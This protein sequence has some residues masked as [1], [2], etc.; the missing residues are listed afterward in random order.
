MKKI[1]LVLLLGNFALSSCKK[2]K[3]APENE[4]VDQTPS[5]TI[6]ASSSPQFTG[7]LDGTT[8]NYN[9]GYH[10]S[11]NSGGSIGTNP[12]PSNFTFGF[13]I[14]NS[15]NISVLKIEKG[16][17]I[18]PTGGY[19]TNELFGSFFTLGDLNYDSLLNNGV[20]VSIVDNLGVEWSTKNSSADQTNSTFKILDRIEGVYNGDFQVKVK[21]SLSCK[22]YDNNGNVKV[23]TDGIVVGSFANI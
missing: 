9:S 2:D 5:T 1:L 13:E 22:L 14:V 12:D 23:I 18:V 15:N 19:P 4:P 10:V 11:F 16:S 21:I 7:T 6:T 20:E 3:P 17:L 8:F